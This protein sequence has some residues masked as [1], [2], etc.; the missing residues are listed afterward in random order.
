MTDEVCGR[1]FRSYAGF[2]RIRTTV[3]AAYGGYTSSVTA[4]PCHL[5]LQ[6]KAFGAQII[7]KLQFICSY[8]LPHISS[9]VNLPLNLRFFRKFT[10]EFGDG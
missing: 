5:P 10:C 8:T 7:D 6:G 9:F 1:R 2:R 4:L 3:Y